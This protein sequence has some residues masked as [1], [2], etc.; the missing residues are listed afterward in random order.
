MKATSKPVKPR[1]LGVIGEVHILGMIGGVPSADRYKRIEVDVAG[2]PYLIEVGFGYC[3]DN[4][5]RTMVCGLNWSISVG[6]EPFRNVG[7]HLGGLGAVLVPRH[8]GFDSL[9]LV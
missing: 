6:G 9:I 1:D 7:G 5:C 2:V 4:D 3:P 8:S